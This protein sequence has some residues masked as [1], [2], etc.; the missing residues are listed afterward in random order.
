MANDG[1]ISDS[2]STAQTLPLDKRLISYQNNGISKKIT[3][4]H[5]LWANLTYEWIPYRF[6]PK[7]EELDIVG[8]SETWCEISTV[9]LDDLEFLLRLPHHKFWS[10]CIYDDNLQI[11]L[12][13]ILQRLPRQHDYEKINNYPRE[14]LS[15]A[16]KLAH[17]T[18]LVFLRLS[19][20]KESTEFYIT[21]IVFG[22]IIYDT[23]LFD[24][25]K[26]LDICVL[27]H[28]DNSTLVEKMVKNVIEK[29]KGR[30][31]NDIKQTA[32]T[33]KEA[34]YKVQGEIENLLFRTPGILSNNDTTNINQELIYIAS[35]SADILLTIDKFISAYN[36][37][38]IIFYNSHL[39]CISEESSSSMQNKNKSIIKPGMCV[40]DV[41]YASFPDLISAFYENGLIPIYR[42]VIKQKQL[43][44]MSTTMAEAVSSIIQTA[45][46]S[47]I[48]G[49]RTLI[50]SSCIAPM[51]EGT[52]NQSNE[53]CSTPNSPALDLAEAYLLILTSTLSDEH[54]FRDYSNTHNIRDDLEIYKQVGVELDQ[55]CVQNILD[56]IHDLDHKLKETLRETIESD[57]QKGLC[58]SYEDAS[59]TG[60]KIDQCLKT[61]QPSDVDALV[62]QVKDLFSNLGDGFILSCLEHFDYSPEH[63]INCL[64]EDNLPSQLAKMDRKMPKMPVSATNI[65][66]SKDS[67]AQSVNSEPN[68]P[69]LSVHDEA[70]DVA[71]SAIISMHKGK[72]RRAKNANVMLND[73]T[74][75]MTKQM[76]DRFA[77]LSIVVDEEVINPGFSDG[78]YNYDDEYD[79]TYD[80]QAMGEREPDADDL[81]TR[82]PF[83]LPQALGGGHITF[84]NEDSDEDLEH[85]T[86]NP[87]DFVR[88]PEK[89]RE[90]AERKRQEKNRKSGMSLPNRDVVGKKSGQGQEKQVLIN[91]K[92]KT[93]NKGK[94]TRSAADRKMSKGMF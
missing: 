48:S 2:I 8:A 65:E 26:I 59:L 31:D 66:V 10:Q 91:R 35:Y 32:Q 3:G 80:D 29:S 45:R 44:A 83:V 5:K 62:L 88:N 55:V 73:K 1:C 27:F 84:V 16:R 58:H 94:H 36:P 53:P 64:L 79:D 87:L 37:A 75:L 24:I 13:R 49:F 41:K 70:F 43:G 12:G 74:D 11:H 19:T 60:N 4:I 90:E 54:F 86:K 46:Q 17:K 30:Y 57:Q 61:A 69:P 20:H 72:Q 33:I 28:D 67:I 42:R 14:I 34:L 39:Y 40:D 51:L 82:R 38:A 78:L 21:P 68:E 47:A 50:Y 76:K 18:F 92:N 81:E 85:E 89:V 7:I 9:V 56:V 25:P 63:L 52:E 6:P 23:Y 15:I 71:D 77:A 22:K 93:E